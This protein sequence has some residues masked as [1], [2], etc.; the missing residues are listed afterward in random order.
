[1]ELLTRHF[2]FA[3]AFSPIWLTRPRCS[4]VLQTSLTERAQGRGRTHPTLSAYRVPRRP[5]SPHTLVFWRVHASA[6]L[7]EPLALCES[8]AQARFHP[9]LTPSCC[10]VSRARQLAQDYALDS[11]ASPSSNRVRREKVMVHSGS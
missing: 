3:H 5:F 7:T 6:R 8:V 2:R 1:V 11:Y 10:V 4:R 9:F